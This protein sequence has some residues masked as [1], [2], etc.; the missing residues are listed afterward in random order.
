MEGNELLD[1]WAYRVTLADN[2]R[3]DSAAMSSPVPSDAVFHPIKVY[4]VRFD[5]EAML[6]VP[7]PVVAAGGVSLD[8]LLL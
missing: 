3:F 6:T 5:A 7:L 8:P 2:A 1:H 4:P